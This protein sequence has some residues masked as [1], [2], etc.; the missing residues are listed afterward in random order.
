MLFETYNGWLVLASLILAVLASYTALDMARRVST[1]SGPAARWWMTGGAVALGT[2]IWSMHFLGMLALKLPI[3]MGYDPRIT[4]LSLIIAIAS[5]AYALA[6]VCLKRLTWVRLCMG[7]VLMGSGV[8]VMHYLGMAAM[9][10]HPAIRYIPSLVVLSIAIAITASGLAL[11]IAFRLRQRSSN[12]KWLQACAASVM[13]LAI[14]G[15]HYTGMAAAQFP[16]N[17]ICLNAGHGIESK[18]VATT[19][20]ISTLAI[21]SIALIVSML[22]LKAGM[23]TSALAQARTE[24]QFLALHDN[25]TKLPNRRLF[26]GRLDQQIA[27]SDRNGSTFSVLFVD[28]DGFK[29]INDA[30]GHY[31]GDALLVEV[32]GRVR[33]VV[34]ASD[35]V[36]RFG[37][38]EFVLLADTA[39]PADAAALANKIIHTLEQPFF[40]AGHECQVTASIG[41]SLYADGSDSDL[42]VK[43]ADAAMYRAKEMGRNSY[44]FFDSSMNEDAEKQLQMVHDLR[45]ALTRNELELYYQPKLDART[46]TVQGVEALIRWNHPKRGLL[47]PA[48]FIPLAEKFGLILPIGQWTVSEAC[49]QMSEWRASGYGHLTVAI[50]LSAAQF[51]HS[52]LICLVRENLARYSIEPSRLML[53][54]TEST[55]MCDPDASLRILQQLRAIGVR[56][57]IDDFGTGYSSLMYLRRLPASE[58]KIDRGF[59]RELPQQ[60]EDAAIISA[61]VALGRTLNLQIV[62]EGVETLEQQEMLTGLGCT[63]LQ[64]Y[65]I[66][67]PMPADQLAMALE[68][69]NQAQQPENSSGHAA[70]LLLAHIAAG[71][72]S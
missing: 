41:I 67:R 51:N 26:Q 66:G 60:G 70:P 58:L 6:M 44:R 12:P 39:E 18:W 35:T 57:S 20:I 3:P 25:L 37:G 68:R 2:G 4:F 69:R 50:N 29:Q 28:L 31:I 62:A 40:I 53:E 19:V 30:Y 1:H 55:A 64:G 16:L 21:L 54:V 22:D 7:A 56:I 5:S 8:C 9:E 65:L 15:M 46:G 72:H 14:A 38:D 52:D 33:S 61:I 11:W 47:Q 23:L 71:A 49:R 63:L 48:E 45:K 32:A 17:S 24:L 42:L 34:R 43:N 10:M 13:G 36:A 27:D 59:V